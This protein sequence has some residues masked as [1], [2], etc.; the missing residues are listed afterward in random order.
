MK[1]LNQGTLVAAVLAFSLAVVSAFAA[2]PVAIDGWV[3]DSK[4]GAKH[5]AGDPDPDCVQKCIKGGAAPVFVDANNKVWTID[6]P[7]A[8]KAHYG[9]HVTVMADVNSDAGS[10]HISKVKMLPDQGK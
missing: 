10:V 5:G 8:V 7:D 2:A 4:C 6:N 9:H 1:I 3:A